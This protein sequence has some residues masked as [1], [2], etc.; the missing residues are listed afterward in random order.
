MPCRTNSALLLLPHTK[1][2]IRVDV[3]FEPMK[4]RIAEN[5]SLFRSAND[6]IELEAQSFQSR[7]EKVPFVC[8]CP[9]LSCT[10]IVE[11]T[12]YDYEYIRTGPTRFFVVPGHEALAVQAGAAIVIEGRDGVC[13][14][15]KIGIAGQV[16]AAH[17]GDEL[18]P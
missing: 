5:E 6:E 7:G 3:E 12:L 13:I 10:D 14:S 8:E 16:A 15:E 18:V 17:H 9:D 4:V 2:V 1:V 11:L